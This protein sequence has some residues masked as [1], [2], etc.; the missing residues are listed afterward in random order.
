[1][2]NLEPEPEPEPE[3]QE[4]AEGS[5]QSDTDSWEWSHLQVA[6]RAGSAL[7]VPLDDVGEPT[8]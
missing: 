6:L 5:V 8:Q 2:R 4:V 1:M 7:V 3:Q